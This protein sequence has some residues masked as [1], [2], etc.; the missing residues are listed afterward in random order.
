MP[1][2]HPVTVY[3]DPAAGKQLQITAS[4]VAAFLWHVAHKVFGILASHK[5][6]HGWSCHSIQVTA[7]NLLHRARFSD[8]YIKICLRWCSDTFLV[9]LHNTFY[10]ADQHT[11]TITLSLDPLKPDLIRLLKQQ[12]LWL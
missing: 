1:S 11:K 8:S 10:M 4:Q 5:D 12:K 9:Y 6:I 7:T 3:C 2:A